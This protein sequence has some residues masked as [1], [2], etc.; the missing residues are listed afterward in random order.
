MT[1]SPIHTTFPSLRYSEENLPA[2]LKQELSSLP[3][4]EKINHLQQWLN[5]NSRSK[6]KYMLYM[7]MYDIEDNKIRT[8]IAK[9]LIRKGCLRIQKSVYIL[10]TNTSE[11]KDITNTLKEVNEA[12]ANEDS[13]LVLPIP[14]E[15]FNNLRMIGKNITFEVVTKPK[16]VLI[17]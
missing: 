14:Q 15:K 5:S 8:H 6:T 9:Y 17:F 1:E 2:S 4:E 16:N 10:K 12:Y 3:M 7:I 11:I 13:I